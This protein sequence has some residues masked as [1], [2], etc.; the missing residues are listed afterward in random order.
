MN[1][2]R[3]LHT[4]RGA[5]TAPGTASLGEEGGQWGVSVDKGMEVGRPT[6]NKDDTPYQKA[7]CPN[8]P[9]VLGRQASSI[10][11]LTSKPHGQRTKETEPT[12]RSLK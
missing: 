6:R 9:A 5:D 3:Y 11:S 7:S 1:T 4:R 2:A 12:I 8:T 10:L